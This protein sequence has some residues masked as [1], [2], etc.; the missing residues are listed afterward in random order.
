MAGQLWTWGYNIFGGLGDNTVASKSSPVQTIALGSNWSSVACGVFSTAAIKTD[1]TLW[2]WGQ[3]SN[4]QLGDNT[5]TN[6]SSPIQTITYGTNWSNVAMG[7]N[8]VAAIKNDGTLWTWGNNSSG[9]L[10]DNTIVAKSSPVQTIAE[11]TN[12]SSVACGIG[13]TAAIK[14]DGT[15]WTWGFNYGGLGDNTNI[16]RS[17]PVQT[18]AGGTNWSKVSCGG[19]YFTAAIKTDGTLWMWGSNAYGQLGDNTVNS[20]SSP[21][22]T[23]AGG[24]N[25]SQVF[26]GVL[27]VVALKTD[28]TL[29]SWGANNFG[30]LGD[31]TRIHRS[32]PVQT[33]AYGT[34]WSQI[35]LG[36]SYHTAAVKVD[37]TLWTWGRNNFGQIGDNTITNKSSPIQTIAYGTNWSQVSCGFFHTIAIQENSANQLG[38]NTQP[39]AGYNSNQLLVQPKIN[40]NDSAGSLVRIANNSVSVTV[41]SGTATLSGTTTVTAVNG[42]ATFT[43]LVLTGSGAITLRFTSSGLTQVDSSSFTVSLTLPIIPK[44]SEVPGKV[45]TS[46]QL[47]IGELAVNI[48]DKKGYVKK[49]DG[50]IV[51]LFNGAVYDGGTF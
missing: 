45:P 43:D 4:G 12:W 40:I 24:N 5:I 34:N 27:Y 46:G 38:I 15:L 39:L 10:G 47:N 14:T 6:K 16:H 35:T 19:I 13:H 50:T 18:I 9:P 32:S 17:S 36:G 48:A 29:W 11:G 1:G 7:A 51:S 2:T 37:G 8:H 41:I 33:I 23:I 20:R 21:V 49:S 25:W 30:Q 22:Q 31:N 44:R 3:N 26:C 28:G 42:V